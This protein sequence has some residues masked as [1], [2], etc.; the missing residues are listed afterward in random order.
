MK[1]AIFSQQM[2]PQTFFMISNQAKFDS[3]FLLA[4]VKLL[5]V[6]QSM[7]LASKQIEHLV[8]THNKRQRKAMYV[9]IH[10]Y[11]VIKVPAIDCRFIEA[12]YI[13]SFVQNPLFKHWATFLSLSLEKKKC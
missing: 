12:V 13:A 4:P 3:C 5:P 2:P 11:Y 7:V 1:T 8:H 6:L 9:I 10:H